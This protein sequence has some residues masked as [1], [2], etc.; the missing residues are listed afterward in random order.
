MDLGPNCANL[1]HSLQMVWTQ[2]GPKIPG[3]ICVL[4]VCKDYLKK[5]SLGGKEF[6]TMLI[7]C[8]FITG[9]LTEKRIHRNI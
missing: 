4:T 7:F 1:S 8:I 6:N 2:V 5:L 3:P 9:M